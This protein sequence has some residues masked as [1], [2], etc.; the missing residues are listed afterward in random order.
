MLFYY[1]Q[2]EI[3]KSQNI[4]YNKIDELE[5]EIIKFRDSYLIKSPKKSHNNKSPK[6]KSPKEIKGKEKK[7]SQKK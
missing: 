6:K 4:N 2:G 5:K 3:K 1:F 7:S